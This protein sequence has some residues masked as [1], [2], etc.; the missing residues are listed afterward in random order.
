MAFF[1]PHM[2]YDVITGSGCRMNSRSKGQTRTRRT[3]ISAYC[4]IDGPQFLHPPASRKPKSR[5]SKSTSNSYTNIETIHEI[6]PLD[7][8]LK[9]K[10]K[11]QMN[12][13]ESIKDNDDD[14]EDDEETTS[15]EESS[16]SLLKS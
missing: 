10:I 14:N 11:K 16:S 13:L 15:L 4:P 7:D 1:L 8:D 2:K 9:A 12:Q 5:F 3:T 6:E